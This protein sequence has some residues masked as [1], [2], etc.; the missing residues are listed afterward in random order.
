M[1]SIF[2]HHVASAPLL[3]ELYLQKQQVKKTVNLE[4]NGYLMYK[5]QIDIVIPWVNYSGGYYEN[6]KKPF[7]FGKPLHNIVS[8]VGLKRRPWTEICWTVRSLFFHGSKYIRN[9]YIVYN[10]YRHAAPDCN[11]GEYVI[12]TAQQTFLEGTILEG[13][14]SPRPHAVFPF[15]HRIQTL[16]DYFL[17]S[18]DD[19]FLL[20]AFDMRDFF[21]WSTGKIITHMTGGLSGIS[22]GSYESNMALKNVFGKPGQYSD[23]LHVPF[24]VKKKS[25]MDMMH[26]LS[27]IFSSCSKPTHLCDFGI[28][29]Q[30]LIQNYMIMSGAARNGSPIGFSE[31]HTTE[32]MNLGSALRA[33]KNKWLNVQGTGVSD[34]YGGPERSR[35]RLRKEFD[36]WLSEQPFFAALNRKSVEKK[37]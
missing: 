28:Q 3:H 27:S 32:A 34:E 8:S 23:G 37:K 12:P 2:I 33:N 5:D 30:T 16:G 10:G 24:L 35:I 26:S 7:D 20:K 17:F 14:S 4:Q 29:Y 18:M 1:L 22:S 9:V 11:F 21:D 31:I 36:S 13:Q 25:Q 15:L 19:I 6:P